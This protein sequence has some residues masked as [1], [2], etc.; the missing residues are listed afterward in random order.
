MGWYRQKCKCKICGDKS[1]TF[2]SVIEGKTHLYA[3]H[4]IPNSRARDYLILLGEIKKEVIT[5]YG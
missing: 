4:G 3:C 2:S 1:Y 5:I